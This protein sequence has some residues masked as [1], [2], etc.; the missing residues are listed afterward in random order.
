MSACHGVSQ[1]DSGINWKQYGLTWISLQRQCLTI[2]FQISEFDLARPLADAG[3]E[4]CLAQSA[5]AVADK[6]DE[7]LAASLAV[8]RVWLLCDD[9]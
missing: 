2:Q 9:V 6:G 4:A 7:C 1:G 3:T 8:V 5:Q